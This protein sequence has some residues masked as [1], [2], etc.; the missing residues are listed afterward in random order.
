MSDGVSLHS[1]RF[2]VEDVNSIDANQWDNAQ[3]TKALP[4]A[5]VASANRFSRVAEGKSTN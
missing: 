5:T 4:H 3:V 2:F 1:S